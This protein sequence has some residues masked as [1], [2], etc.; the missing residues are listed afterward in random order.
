ML[1]ADTSGVSNWRSERDAE[2]GAEFCRRG[3]F[4]STVRLRLALTSP[5]LQLD[6]RAIARG[7][8]R[9]PTALG[10]RGEE[11]VCAPRDVPTVRSAEAT[12]HAT[13]K[14]R[15]RGRDLQVLRLPSAGQGDRRYG[16][17]RCA[18]EL[19]PR[20]SLANAAQ[21]GSSLPS[22]IRF[23]QDVQRSVPCTSRRHP[24]THVERLPVGIQITR[25]AQPDSEARGMARVQLMTSASCHPLRRS[26]STD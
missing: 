16:A 7:C 10:Q 23:T 13:R 18:S 26:R 6:A 4:G 24:G 25:G 5:D 21:N 2:Q 8:I 15:V 20:C 1:G 14:L 19:D 17:C 22:S 12:P 9:A 11:D 3:R